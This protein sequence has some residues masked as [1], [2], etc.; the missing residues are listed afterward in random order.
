MTQKNKA[1]RHVTKCLNSMIALRELLVARLLMT[2]VFAVG[3]LPL[4][5]VGDGREA[6]AVT[7]DSAVAVFALRG[8][9][10][11]SVDFD[12]S[13]NFRGRCRGE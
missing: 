11:V 10:V 7:S 9:M 6:G 5:A 8:N 4:L 13:W 3:F 1:L 12:G 2:T